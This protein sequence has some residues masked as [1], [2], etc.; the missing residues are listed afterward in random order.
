MNVCAGG[1][2]SGRLLLKINPGLMI[3]TQAGCAFLAYKEDSSPPVRG[4]M[5]S[6][7]TLKSPEC[8]SF[9]DQMVGAGD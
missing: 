3:L 7:G 5:I 9:Q 8:I 4:H 1:A 2:R 6:G